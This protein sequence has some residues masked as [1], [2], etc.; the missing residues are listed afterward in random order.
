MRSGFLCALVLGMSISGCARNGGLES[1]PDVALPP[2]AA[3]SPDLSTAKSCTGL[4]ACCGAGVSLLDAVAPNGAPIDADDG[5][6]DDVVVRIAIE[7]A[8][9]PADG[10][11]TVKATVTLTNKAGRPI[12]GAKARLLAEPILQA[13][14]GHFVAR[15]RMRAHPPDHRG[16]LRALAR[17][18]DRRSQV[19][20]LSDGV[21]PVRSPRQHHRHLWRR[22]SGIHHER[23]LSLLRHGGLDPPGLGIY[24]AP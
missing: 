7:P 18:R 19:R 11:S 15:K 1:P 13:P 2:D 9:V 21:L 5:M 24:L 10:H 14:D 23:V 20:R 22:W 4:D 8:V 12:R 6:P 3:S 17:W 16:S